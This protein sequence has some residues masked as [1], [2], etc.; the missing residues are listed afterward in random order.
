[1]AWK[2]LRELD[3]DLHGLRNERLVLVRMHYFCNE[4]DYHG[5]HGLKVP[6]SLA[7][8]LR[9]PITVP[10]NRHGDE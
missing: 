4:C 9:R 6:E 3:P 10:H 2:T 7:P 5:A 1:M 8:K